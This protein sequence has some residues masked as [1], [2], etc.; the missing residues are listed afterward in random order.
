[1]PKYLNAGFLIS[2]ALVVVVVALSI[3]SFLNKDTEMDKL[4]DKYFEAYQGYPRVGEA[5]N[6]EISFAQA[7]DAYRSGDFHKSS[8]LLHTISASDTA[9]AEHFFFLGNSLLAQKPP[10]AGKAQDAFREVFK[11][12]DGY[13]NETKWYFGLASLKKKEKDAA[14]TILW[15]IARKGSGFKQAE[16]RKIVDSLLED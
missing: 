16:A 6:G 9:T 8:K 12:K 15:E 5:T 3:V 4:F 11:L 2:M 10:K 14:R 7:I 1:M 13:I